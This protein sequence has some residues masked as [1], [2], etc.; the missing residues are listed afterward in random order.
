[1]NK[2]R[3][4][5]KRVK[6]DWV[7]SFKAVSLVLDVSVAD[8]GRLVKDGELTMVESEVF[9]V[10]AITKKSL[11]NYLKKMQIKRDESL[12]DEEWLSADEARAFLNIRETIFRSLVRRGIISHISWGKYS[13]KDIEN[14]KKRKGKDDGQ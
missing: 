9:L 13:K 1:M 10:R 8:V 7:R 3:D 11:K 6:S 14:Y 4:R 5:P 12:R 2:A